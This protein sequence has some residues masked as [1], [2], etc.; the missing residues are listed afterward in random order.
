M[1]MTTQ[2]TNESAYIFH[3]GLASDPMLSDTAVIKGQ[4]GRVKEEALVGVEVTT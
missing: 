4:Y 3:N 2:N 1:N